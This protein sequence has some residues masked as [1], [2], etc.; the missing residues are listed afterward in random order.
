M[1]THDSQPSAHTI[2]V[3]ALFV[4][5]HSMLRAFILAL[6]PDFNTAQD[7][8]QET[9]LTVTSKAN[10]FTPGTNFFNWARA[11]ARYKILQATSVRRTGML[12][13][14][15]MESLSAVEVPVTDDR[16]I[17]LLNTCIEGLTPTP[18]A[19]SNCVTKGATLRRR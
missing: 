2:A 10:E 5:H 8:L 16:R 13:A 15:A 18:A 4:Q 1:A 7:V 6:V 3:Q 9:F 14:A 17:P 12:S 11:I 19:S